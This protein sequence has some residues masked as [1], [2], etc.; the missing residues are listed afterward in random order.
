[1]S[2]ILF[3]ILRVQI[4]FLSGPRISLSG[5]AYIFLQ[6]KRQFLLIALVNGSA[7]SQDQTGKSPWRHRRGDHK[8]L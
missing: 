3:I 2:N 8:L 6:K 7:G 5:I 1:M 4:I